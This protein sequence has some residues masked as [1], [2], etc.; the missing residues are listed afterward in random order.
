VNLTQIGDATFS[1][2]MTVNGQSTFNALINANAGITLGG[3][4]TDPVTITKNIIGNNISELALCPGDDGSGNSITLPLSGDTVQDY[5]TVRTNAGVHHAFSTSG[6]YYCAGNIV[7]TG[8][9]TANAFNAATGAIGTILNGNLNTV[10][11]VTS[12]SAYRLGYINV[13]AGTWI[14]SSQL[15]V[16]G[17][18]TAGTYIHASNCLSLVDGAV[19]GDNMTSTGSQMPYGSQTQTTWYYKAV[20]TTT[21][22]F[23]ISISFSSGSISIVQSGCYLKAI[24]IS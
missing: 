13:T 17:L 7:V 11:S 3:T 10:S 9:V 21:I 22:Y 2:L 23:N 6:N 20:S 8:T 24:R 1:N 4:N 14:V 15:Q 18:G 19:N 5:V 12:G 16:Y